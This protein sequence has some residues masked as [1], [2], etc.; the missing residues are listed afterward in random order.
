MCRTGFPA[1][2][3]ENH[4]INPLHFTT[5]KP[6]SRHH[7]NTAPIRDTSPTCISYGNS[8]FDIV[9]LMIHHRA[10]FGNSTPAPWLFEE[11]ACEQTLI[12]ERETV[13]GSLTW[14]QGSI[15]LFDIFKLLAVGRESTSLCRFRFS[16]CARIILMPYFGSTIPSHHSDSLILELPINENT[17][18]GIIMSVMSTYS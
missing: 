2:F 12:M 13:A 4:N 9:K 11:P 15:K 8:L 1:C 6:S 18:R 17:E 5:T 3:A 10:C 14:P 7:L 16:D